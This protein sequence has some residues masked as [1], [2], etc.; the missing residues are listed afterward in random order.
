VFGYGSL[1]HVEN[2]SAFL[3]RHRAEF[4]AHSHAE[5]I[6][7]QRTWTVAMDNSETLAGY[8]YYVDTATG[9][10]PEVFVAFANIE[11]RQGARVA[12][13]L[14]EVTHATLEILD[15]R[16]RNY[17]RTDVTAHVSLAVEGTVW[18]YLGSSEATARFHLGRK[19]NALVI[20]EAY[21][22]SIET[23][24]A[25]AGLPYDAGLPAHIRRMALKRV[26][27]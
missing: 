27:T 11:S 22:R 23:A 9:A 21:A 15:A 12:G 16:E 5:L 20:D 2:L 17:K 24:Y 7:F 19:K 25:R 3:A 8:K 26:D 13:I 4:D 10:R 18:T 6:G 1:A 14:F